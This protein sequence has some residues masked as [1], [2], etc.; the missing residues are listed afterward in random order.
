MTGIEIAVGYVFA[1]AVRKARRVAGRADEEL[2]RGL[3][4]GMDWLHELV[5]AKLGS[6]T[7]LERTEQE[8]REG[9][10]ELSERTRLRLRLAL[11]DAV[12]GDETF[13]RALA[14]AVTTLR[15]QADV[16]VVVTASAHRSVAVG[17]NA[18][19]VITGDYGLQPAAPGTPVAVPVPDEDGPAPGRGAVEASGE[20]AVAVGNDAGEIITGDGQSQ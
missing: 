7:A 2:D 16:P 15:N 5:S 12:E 13:A 19:R 4:A 18:G 3:D 8:A 10:S 14:E 17:R 11:E 6:D 1:W 9:A 20:R